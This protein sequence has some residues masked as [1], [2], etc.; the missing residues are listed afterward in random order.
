MDKTELPP[1]LTMKDAAT[2]LRRSVKT[3]RR[4]IEAGEIR[5]YRDVREIRIR[6]EWLLEY[7]AAK[8]TQ[9]E[10]LVAQ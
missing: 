6:R 2:Y 7:E 3:I 4:R 5:Y 8:I 9:S 1:V 10:S